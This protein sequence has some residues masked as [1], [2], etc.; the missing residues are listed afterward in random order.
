[1][2]VIMVGGKTKI[3][4]KIE[5][6]K[7]LN[8]NTALIVTRENDFEPE[9]TEWINPDEISYIIDPR[10]DNLENVNVHLSKYNTALKRENEQLKE[11]LINLQKISN[12]KKIHQ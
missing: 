11:E 2:K 12:N 6:F 5:I 3:C 10:K 7:K 9:I 8:A 4:D 1:M